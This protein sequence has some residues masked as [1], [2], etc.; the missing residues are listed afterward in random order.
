MVGA[1]FQTRIKHIV[2]SRVALKPG[3][4]GQCIVYVTLHPEAQ[5]FNA[6]QQQKAVERTLRWAKI[7]QAFDTGTDGKLN[8][9]QA[10]RVVYAKHIFKHQTVVAFRR[11]AKT[12]ELSV[13]VVE[14]SA[15]NYHTAN[16]GAVSANPLGSTVYYHVGTVCKGLKQVAA[17]TKG[18]VDHQ[19]Y[20]VRGCK[21]GKFFK[22]GDIEAGIA[23]GFEVD[24]LC[25]GINKRQ[26]A[27]DIVAIAK[28]HVY[29]EALKRHLKLVMGAAI[30]VRGR[31]KVV[32]RLYQI[33][34]RQKL[35][36]LTAAGCYGRHAA[37]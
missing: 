18:I 37:L 34:E 25:F 10:K 24:G 23:D 2:Y 19:G 28:A 20:V 9:G 16:A 33:V 32:A 36:C 30:Q 26:K 3:G 12:G 11:F 8:I 1:T 21:C 29:A 35:C 27:V 22:I 7:A 6:L 31:H 14:I 13:A 5:R 15:I 4:Q 17:R